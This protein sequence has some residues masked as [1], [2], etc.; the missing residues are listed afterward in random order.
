[1]FINKSK[2]FNLIKYIYVLVLDLVLLI[3][4]LIKY[5]SKRIFKSKILFNKIKSTNW[6]ESE[7]EKKSRNL[8]IKYEYEIL[9]KFLSL[10][11]SIKNKRRKN[12]SDF[13]YEMF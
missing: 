3:Y 6:K 2:I 4:L 13:T 10:Y 1:M 7:Y 11:P 9:K 8:I 5:L 12:L